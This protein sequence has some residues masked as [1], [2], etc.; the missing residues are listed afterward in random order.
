MKSAAGVTQAATALHTNKAC[1]VLFWIDGIIKTIT[2]CQM[3]VWQQ[4][5][6]VEMQM[7]VKN[8][9]THSCVQTEHQ[10]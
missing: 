8:T 3:K 5:F 9:H 6:P 4:R 2:V 10:L 1:A 7:S